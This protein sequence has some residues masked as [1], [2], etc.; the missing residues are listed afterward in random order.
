MSIRP[1]T[2]RDT[3][4]VCE[5]INDGASAYRGNIPADCWHEPYMPLAALQREID[6]GVVFWGWTKGGKL[7]GVMGIQ[8]KGDVT[9]VRHAYVRTAYRRKGIG[10]R[11]LKHLKTLT[12]K[13]V[14]VGTWKAARWALQFYSQNGF[15]RVTEDEKDRLL[16]TY[17]TIPDR[18]VETSC[19]LADGPWFKAGPRSAGRAGDRTPTSD[20]SPPATWP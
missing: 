18:Q 4:E 13:P 17:W 6:D 11:L 19:V 8:D 7:L 16:R 20:P 5:I 1:C 15:R 10:G 14:L 3:V 2:P 12:R 9:L